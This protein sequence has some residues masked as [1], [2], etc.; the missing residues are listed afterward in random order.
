VRPDCCI[1]GLC[2][3]AGVNGSRFGLSTKICVQIRAFEK[4]SAWPLLQMFKGAPA[5]SRNGVKRTK[6]RP[7]TTDH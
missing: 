4:R 5:T 2:L 7:L 1:D 6:R 3:F